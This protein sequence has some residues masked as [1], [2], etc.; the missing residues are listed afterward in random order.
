M[1]KWCTK[2]DIATAAKKK[3]VDEKTTKEALHKLYQFIA[4]EEDC[5]AEDEVATHGRN[6]SSSP[7]PQTL[8][9]QDK[10]TIWDSDKEQEVDAITSQCKRMVAIHTSLILTE[11]NR[12][13]A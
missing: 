7:L 6:L 12:Q 1:K 5:L 9:H 11:R 10:S 13:D 4:N 3:K 8:A 2:E